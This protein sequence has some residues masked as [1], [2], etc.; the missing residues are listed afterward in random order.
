MLI[1]VLYCCCFCKNSA[2]SASASSSPTP[3][4]GKASPQLVIPN[5]T[6][7]S[8][9]PNKSTL[10]SSTPT[11]QPQSSPQSPSF[12]IGSNSSSSPNPPPLSSLSSTKPV[13]NH[14]K[15]NLAPKPPGMIPL[16]GNGTRSS[17][18]RH[19]SMRSPRYVSL[20]STLCFNL[21]CQFW[22]TA[23]FSLT[24]NPGLRR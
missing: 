20:V 24:R 18:A 4:N 22:C 2:T 15:P 8:L 14:G 13:I 7:M 10:F 5:N 12:S 3:L 1:T 6:G 16:V 19:Q 9:L 21:L 11:P 23:T 17:V